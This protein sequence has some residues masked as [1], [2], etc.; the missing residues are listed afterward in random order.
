MYLYYTKE[1]C[2]NAMKKIISIVLALAV[3]LSLLL[4]VPA[5]YAE[6]VEPVIPT[7]ETVPQVP[8]PTEEVIPET[9]PHQP[10]TI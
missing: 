10:D 9:F 3:C 7:E 6:D 4:A 5:V 8:A 2:V 1:R